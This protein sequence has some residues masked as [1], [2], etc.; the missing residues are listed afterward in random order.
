MQSTSDLVSE[1]ENIEQQKKAG[2]FYVYVRHAG[3]TSVV[4]LSFSAGALTALQS[5]GLDLSGCLELI[6][7]G[8]LLKTMFVPATVEASDTGK[9]PSIGIS[10]LIDLVRNSNDNSSTDS[11]EITV[12]EHMAYLQEVV[13]DIMTDLIGDSG[14][15]D[16]KIIASDIS[17]YDRPRE[18]LDACRDLVAQVVGEGIADQAF[19]EVYREQL[20]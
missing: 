8:T 15:N 2:K 19:E 10:E 11:G 5:K 9:P 6:T 16:I 7:H 3:G 12:T 4:N 17:P 14:K 1:L 13:T 20:K 18:F